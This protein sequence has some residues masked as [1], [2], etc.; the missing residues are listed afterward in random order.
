M[1]S[2]AI[3]SNISGISSLIFK[4]IRSKMHVKT[5]CEK[6]HWANIETMLFAASSE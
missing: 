1:F 2:K 6:P 4:T 5:S 3:I